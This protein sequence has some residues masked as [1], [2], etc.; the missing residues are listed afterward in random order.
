MRKLKGLP[1]VGIC[2]MCGEWH[3][4]GEYFQSGPKDPRTGKRL[5]IILCATF[6]NRRLLPRTHSAMGVITES[7]VGK[8][9]KRDF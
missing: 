3:S 8:Q 2:S 5:T 9:R 6:A 4:R 1:G 7:R